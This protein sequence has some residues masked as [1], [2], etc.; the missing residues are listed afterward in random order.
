M[1]GVKWVRLEASFP[2]NPKILELAYAGRHRAITVYVCGL[3][4]SG[5]QGNEGWIPAPALAR[6]HGRKTDATHLVNAG[7]W[8]PRPGGWEIHDWL[9][10]QPTNDAIALRTKRA[11]AAAETR[12][13]TT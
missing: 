3:A 8:I 7:L 1:T 6:I 10:Y 11:R 9:D 12:W 5:A 4:Y 2:D 13:G